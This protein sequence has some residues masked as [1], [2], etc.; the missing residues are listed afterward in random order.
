MHTIK[1]WAKAFLSICLSAFFAALAGYL[2]THDHIYGASLAIIL[3]ISLT[4]VSSMRIVEGW[5]YRYW[6]ENK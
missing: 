4:V 3:F 5:A 2:L 6:K 1:M